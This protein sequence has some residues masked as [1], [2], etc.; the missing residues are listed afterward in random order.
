MK[1][2]PEHPKARLPSSLDFTSPVLHKET[3]PAGIDKP[4]FIHSRTKWSHWTCVLH[5]AG[6]GICEVF[7]PALLHPS[8]STGCRAFWT[9]LGKTAMPAVLNIQFLE[10]SFLLPLNEVAVLSMDEPFQGFI[11]VSLLREL[12]PTGARAQ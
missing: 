7:I 10:L 8:H 9:A 12:A 4:S 2:I 3:Y 1:F 6:T 11:F 5:R